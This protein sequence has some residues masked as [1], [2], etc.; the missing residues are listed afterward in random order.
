M[1]HIIRDG[2]A[3]DEN[4]PL[5]KALQ[6]LTNDIRLFIELSLQETDAAWDEWLHLVIKEQATGCWEKKKCT[7]ND[8]PAYGD[9]THRCW[10]TVGTMCGGKVQGEFAIKYKSCTECDVYRETVFGDPVNEVYEHIITLV[11]SLKTTQDKLKTLAIKDTLTGTYNRNFF[12]VI[13]AN[14]VERSKRYGDKFS[15]IMVDID[16]FK[17]I[18]DT[19]GHLQCASILQNSIRSSDLLVRYGGDEF[20]IVT[21]ES[22]DGECDKLMSR[23]E[24]LMAGWNSDPGNK[25]YSLSVSSGCALFEQGRELMDVIDEADK[26]MYASK[27]KQY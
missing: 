17:Y 12:N 6:Q 20:I 2:V 14:E 3:M 11:H 1:I 21:T 25:E 19:F 4:H 27:T 23:V 16:N 8:C 9:R 26:K 15:I 22:G 10:L 18:N 13:I 7:K 5:S 24:E